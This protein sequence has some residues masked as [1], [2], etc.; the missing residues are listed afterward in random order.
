MSKGMIVKDDLCYKAFTSRGWT[1]GGDW[2]Y[3]K[4]YQHFQKQLK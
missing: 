1:W 2:K 4:D 3:E